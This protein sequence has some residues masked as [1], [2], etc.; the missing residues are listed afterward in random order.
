MCE[1]ERLHR[2]EIFNAEKIER[3]KAQAEL[4][5]LENNINQ[6]NYK[7]NV[8]IHAARRKLCEIEHHRKTL[9]QKK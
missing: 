3:Q 7:Q 6:A 5:N 9:V 2:G 4:Q 1:P 8:C